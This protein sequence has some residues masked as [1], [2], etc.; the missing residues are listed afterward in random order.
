[1]IPSMSASN[2]DNSLEA[3]SS[4]TSATQRASGARSLISTNVAT[5]KSSVSASQ[6]GESSVPG[7]VW[8][9]GIAAGVILFVL[10][11]RK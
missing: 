8:I 1:M 6:A 4:T 11:R 2:T 3:L 9:L 10:Y 5:G 7:W